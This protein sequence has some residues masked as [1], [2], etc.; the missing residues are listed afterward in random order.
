M[1]LT[2][3]RASAADATSIA[4]LHADRWRRHY[5][6]AYSDSFLDGDVLGDRLAVW[7]QRLA[8]PVNAATI[9]AE[10][11]DDLVGFVH[12]AFDDDDAWGSLIDN[13]HVTHAYQRRGI[14]QSLMTQATD[15]IEA[16]AA[17]KAMYLWVLEQNTV[18]Q[19]FYRALGGVCA[20][21]AAVSAPGGD[22]SRLYGAPNKLRMTWPD[23]TLRTGNRS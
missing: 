3:R 12:V 16:H 15:A 6:G 21:K 10:E 1:P 13:L 14:G 17:T 23:T 4:T 9:V 8:N 7:S 22:S 20:E 5:R 11:D 18:A 2:F 19:A